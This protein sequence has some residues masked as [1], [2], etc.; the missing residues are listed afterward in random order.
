MVCQRCQGLMVKELDEAYPRFFHI[1]QDRCVN[2]GM[3]KFNPNTQT[4]EGTCK[5]P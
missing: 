2:C 1:Y 3:V 4:K 5:R